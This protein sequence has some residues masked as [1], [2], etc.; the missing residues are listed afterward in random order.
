MVLSFLLLPIYKMQV[1][2]FSVNCVGRGAYT[3]IKSKYQT[4]NDQVGPRRFLF[5]VCEIAQRWSVGL[6]SEWSLYRY[7]V[8]QKWEV[9][10]A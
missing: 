6:V 4:W 7:P 10:L 1:R 8:V 9:N 2:S 3:E 5:L